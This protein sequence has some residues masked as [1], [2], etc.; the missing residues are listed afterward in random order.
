MRPSWEGGDRM[1]SY[2][3]RLPIVLVVDPVS[4]SRFAM[5]RLL[6]ARFGVIEAADARG[7]REWLASRQDIDAIVVQRELPDGDGSE[8]LDSLASAWAPASLRS[9]VMDRAD[10]ARSVVERLTRSF[11]SRDADRAG[12]RRTSS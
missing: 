4:E 12:D 10:D 3:Q 6:G 7:V 2:A 5:W 8:V 11:F 1:S 9:I